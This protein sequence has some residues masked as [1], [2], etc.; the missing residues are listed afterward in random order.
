MDFIE[1]NNKFSLNDN[2]GG[3]ILYSMHYTKYFKTNKSNSTNKLKTFYINIFWI[4]LK[5]ILL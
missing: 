2:I 3:E 4:N 5:N 1:L